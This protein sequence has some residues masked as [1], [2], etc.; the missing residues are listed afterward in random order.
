MHKIPFLIILLIGI[1]L[2]PFSFSEGIPEWVKN[3]ASW[4]S[5]RQIS[6]TEFT[7]GLEFLINEGIIYIP[8]TEPGPAGPDKII[9]D[10][11]RNTA[12][13]WADGKIPDSEFVNAMKYLIEIGL[14]EVDASSPEIIKEE[15]VEEIIET[16]PVTGKPLLML[17]EGYNHVSTDGKYVLD[18]LI[19]DAD[20]YPNASPN[21]NRNAAYTIDGVRIDVTLYNE[22]GQIHTYD[23]LTKNGFFRYDVLASETNQDGTLWMINNLYTVNIKASLDGQTVEKQIEFL[24]QASAYAYNAGSAIRAPSGLSATAGNDLVKLSWT[25]PS[26]V[27]GISDYTIQYSTDG[28]TWTT[29]TEASVSDIRAADA[30]TDGSNS[31]TELAG[32]SGVDTFTIDGT[33]YAIVTGNSDN[34]VQIID[35]S[36]PTNI[37][38]KDAQD[39]GDAG[40]FDELEGVREVKTFKVNGDTNTYAIAVSPTDDGVQILNITDPTAITA[41]DAETDGANSFTELKGAIAVDVYSIGSSTYA[42]VAAQSD[43]GVQIID[44][45]DPT[46]IVAKDAQ[47]DGDAGGFD[48]LDGPRDVKVFTVSGDSNTYAIVTSF[49]E[50]AVQILNITDPTAITATDSEV[51]GSNS[52]TELEDAF[53]VDVFTIDSSTY[54]IVTGFVDDGVQIIDISD[55]TDIVAKDAETDGANSFTELNGA[56]G[57]DVFTLDS[58]TYAA[59]A[60]KADSGIQILNINDPTAIT[61]TDAQ[62]DGDSGGFTELNGAR[63]VKTFEINSQ[64]YAIITADTD[65]GIQMISL[66]GVG[67]TTSVV[68]DGL[69]NETL[70]YFRVV[71]ENYSG[72][73]KYSSVVSATT[74]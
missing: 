6:Q 48:R 51:D 17:L 42:I 16:N 65:S 70:Y 34:G 7:N 39:D 23:G 8:P 72:L 25:A 61:A 9:P 52:F 54:A 49:A 1:S 29:F 40:G 4:W 55:P 44:I 46:D 66:D 32:A 30:E 58:I 67:S 20:K 71:G 41:T 74:T 73:G 62:D 33:L 56:Q 12:G 63:E 50:H 31:F 3:N 38:A 26:G 60:S 36:D 59:V 69:D 37:V 15:T 35:I 14:I 64:V 53:G 13:W 18:V 11:V 68:V 24:G 21:F 57:V 19:F 5:E 2:I 27:K 10:W 45:S 43:D 22:E 28:N 47:D